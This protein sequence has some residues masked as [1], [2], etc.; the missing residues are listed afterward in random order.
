MFWSIIH[1][2]FLDNSFSSVDF[3]FLFFDLIR[4][5]ILVGT[6]RSDNPEMAA[7]SAGVLLSTSCWRDFRTS[8]SSITRDRTK[9]LVSFHDSGRKLEGKTVPVVRFLLRKLEFY[10]TISKQFCIAGKTYFLFSV[11]S[12]LLRFGFDGASDLEKRFWIGAGIGMSD[13][14]PM[15][16]SSVGVFSWQSFFLFSTSSWLALTLHATAN[17]M[18][19]DFGNVAYMSLM[20]TLLKENI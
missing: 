18:V 8:S 2:T 12:L 10:K 4:V 7:N 16:P 20:L 14:D 9:S 13:N 5:W 3:K 17:S 6:G 1:L 19:K 11:K 15:F